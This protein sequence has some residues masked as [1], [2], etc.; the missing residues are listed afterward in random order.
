MTYNT[1]VIADRYTVDV[2][3]EIFNIGLIIQSLMSRTFKKW[4]DGTDPAPKIEK[5]YGNPIYSD[6]LY[7]AVNCCTRLDPD[8]RPD[9]PDLIAYTRKGLETARN[10]PDGDPVGV[11]ME[12]IPDAFKLPT[13]INAKRPGDFMGDEYRIVKKRLTEDTSRSDED[14]PDTSDEIPAK[15]R[16]T[17]T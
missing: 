16:R 10:L 11:S 1:K 7:N 12:N 8:S 15:K 14:Q 4:K 5:V 17:S 9:L 2:H 13:M 3:S 6:K